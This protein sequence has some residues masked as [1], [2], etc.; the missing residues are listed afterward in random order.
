M[1]PIQKLFATFAV[2]CFLPILAN[3]HHSSSEYDETQLVD[4]E[5]VVTTKFWRNPHVMFRVMTIQ[6]GVEEEWTV[7]GASVSNQQRRGVGADVIN[8][9]DKI[10]IAGH[11]STRREHNIAMQHILLSSGQELM[12]QPNSAR[13]WPDVDQASVGPTGP[14][15]AAIAAA[16]ASADGLF[17]VWS[18]GRLERGWWFFGDPDDFPLTAA[19]LQK[20]A[21]WNEYTDNPQLECIAPGM[22]LT[23][24]NPYP[25]EFVQADANTIV[26][27]AH[28]FD[29]T[30]TIHLNA[31]SDRTVP[32][33]NMGY[34]VGRWEDDT[35][36]VVETV[37]ISYPYF[38]RVGIS[39]GPDLETH[40]RFVV[41]E[42][43]GKLHY[44]LTVTD[45]WTL[46]EPYEKE[47]LWIWDPGVEVGRYDCQVEDGAAEN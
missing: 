27:N 41:D 12:L 43:A 14:G 32:E 42:A 22:P 34:S 21:S 8:V 6:D 23:M 37:N 17:R 25:I 39:S 26:M 19:A 38:N 1:A 10:T 9:G 47:L 15:A 7:E 24:G 2:L 45:P 16:Q 31:K 30:R 18:W 4:I 20:F 11:V 44:Y 28:E 3:A 13:R 40:E 46:N 5:G 36:L 29:V 35:T 33:S